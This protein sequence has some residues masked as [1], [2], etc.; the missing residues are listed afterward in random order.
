VTP[1]AQNPGAKNDPFADFPHFQPSTPD[2]YGRGLGDNCRI[3]NLAIASLMAYFQK[4]LPE[5]KYA[6]ALEEDS[7]GRKIFRI[8]KGDRQ[9]YLSILSDAP[10]TV[11]VLAEQKVNKLEDLKG[12]VV[13]PPELYQ[14]LAELVPPPDP[15]DPSAT[16]TA[17]RENFA[18][19]EFFFK[20][21]KNPDDEPVPEALS[22]LD[23]TP[24][25]VPGQTPASLY[26]AIA[27]SLTSIF[28]STSQAGTYAGGPLYQLKKGS[29]TVYLSLVPNK[30]GT[31][32]IFSV[33]LKDPR[34]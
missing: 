7:P 20:P 14:L 21:S 16:N 1:A 8:G 4:A 23:G 18:Q 26:G 10:N 19:P 11:Y 24:Q 17:K 29:V 34:N 25:I 15:N 27:A 28:E 5:K 32:T 9:G 2:C 6:I 3:A 31:G 12:A 13:V 22:G 33:W 30:D